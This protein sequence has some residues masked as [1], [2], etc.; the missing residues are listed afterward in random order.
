MSPATGF[1]GWTFTEFTLSRYFVFVD[2][3]SARVADRFPSDDVALAC[4]YGAAGFQ[5]RHLA[6]PKMAATSTTDM[7]MAV[8]R[9]C[10]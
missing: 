8:G 5:A 10:F 6:N 7:R 3:D 2:G 9:L 1:G 4:C